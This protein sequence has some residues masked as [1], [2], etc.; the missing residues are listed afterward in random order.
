M[1]LFM[2][3]S[4]DLQND[5]GWTALHLGASKGHVEIVQALLAA[6]AAKD[7]QTNTGSDTPLHL[8]VWNNH[9]AIVR[10][11]LAAGAE[12]DI[13]QGTGKTA[14]DLARQKGHTE[15]LELLEAS[16]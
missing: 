15:I 6:G 13:K 3:S 8:A 11:L 4:Q 9:V 12:K 16:D 5:K 1:V 2:R 7:I 10:E 14:A